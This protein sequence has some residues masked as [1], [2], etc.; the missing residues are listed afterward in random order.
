MIN[1]S[2]PTALALLK[3]IEDSEKKEEEKDR[4]E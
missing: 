1:R 2:E 3:K 4:N